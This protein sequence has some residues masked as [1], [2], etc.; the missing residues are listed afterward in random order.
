M[1]VKLPIID[2]FYSD[3]VIH[4]MEGRLKEFTEHLQLVNEKLKKE[5]YGY[6]YAKKLNSEYILRGKYIFSE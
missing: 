5:F 6:F 4:I 2:T 1:E 3:Q